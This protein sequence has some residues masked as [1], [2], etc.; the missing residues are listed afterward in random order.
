MIETYLIYA[1]I[2]CIFYL[3]FT[4]TQKA[5]TIQDQINET[6]FKSGKWWLL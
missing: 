6:K 4:P 3:V 1:I 2:A 5:R